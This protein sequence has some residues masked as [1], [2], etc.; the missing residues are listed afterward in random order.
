MF[1][2]FLIFVRADGNELEQTYLWTKT[3]NDDITLTEV[4]ESQLEVGISSGEI[5]YVGNRI[6]ATGTQ[7]Y[8]IMSRET[9]ERLRSIVREWKTTDYLS[10]SR[11]VK[12][13]FKSLS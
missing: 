8:Y 4:I 7:G 12:R 5:E 10:W 13:M 6:L 2:R 9:F 11:N 3:T 1:K